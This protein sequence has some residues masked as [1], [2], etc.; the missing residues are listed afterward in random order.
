[1]SAYR[2]AFWRWWQ[3]AIR[4]AVTD[5]SEAEKK[6]LVMKTSVWGASVTATQLAAEHV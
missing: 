3:R 4:V 2:E 6:K 1:M 5:E